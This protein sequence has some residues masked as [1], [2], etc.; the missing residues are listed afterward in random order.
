MVDGLIVVVFLFLGFKGR[1]IAHIGDEM[2]RGAARAYHSQ[3][4]GSSG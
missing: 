1:R 2:S 4:E 3:T